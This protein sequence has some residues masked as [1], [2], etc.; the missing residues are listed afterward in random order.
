LRL[1]IHATVA[2]AYFFTA[3]S[4]GS[5][6][7]VSYVKAPIYRYGHLQ[8]S[9]PLVE[10]AFLVQTIN[11]VM[12]SRYWHETAIVIVW[13]D[14]DGWYDHVMPPLVTPSATNVDFLFGPG[15]CGTP[16][17]CGRGALRARSAPA[18]AG[19]IALGQN[20]LR[21]SHA[22]PAGLGAALCRGQLEAW[23]HRR[24]GCAWSW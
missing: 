11:A 18:S 22:D 21:R 6:P 16:A 12:R 4:Y 19:D 7:A 3:L 8:N 17:W 24:S 5:L 15:N 1:E 10:Q 2:R 23:L 20:Q 9:D 14:S 13:D